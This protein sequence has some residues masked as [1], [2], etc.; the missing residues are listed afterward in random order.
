MYILIKFALTFIRTLPAKILIASVHRVLAIKKYRKQVIN[1]NYKSTIGHNESE[2]KFDTF[3]NQCILNIAKIMVETLKFNRSK[4][5]LLSYTNIEKLEN[6]CRQKNGL[7]L[8]ASHY[9]NWELACI[10]LPLHT[11]LP[12]YGV[13]KPLKN[14]TLD[15]ELIELRSKFGLHLVP[16]NAIARSMAKNHDQS[17]PAIYILIADQ[18]PRSIQSVVW[19]EFLGILSAFSNG[20]TKFQN[21]Y[22][23]SIAYMNITPGPNNF[24]YAIDFDFPSPEDSKKPIQWYSQRVEN[25]IVKAPQYWLWSHKRWKRKYQPESN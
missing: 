17:K 14:K 23:F 20:L 18:N 4:S 8:M 13:Y 15:K 9:G 19:I 10:N 1:N 21:K 7:V 22:N 3:Y 5:K 2:D 16:M 11:S 24:E 25:Q 6:Q 12:C